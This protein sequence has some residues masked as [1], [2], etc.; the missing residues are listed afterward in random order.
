M[1]DAITWW[2][3][4][5][6]IGLAAFPLAFVLFCFLPDRGYSFSKVFGLLL[7]S[8]LVWIGASAHVIPNHRWSIVLVLAL[9]VALCTFLAFRCRRDF[10]AFLRN[11]WSHLLVMDLVFAAVYAAVLFFHSYNAD[12]TLWWTDNPAHNAFI[13][14]ILRSDYFPP[15]DPWLSG[16]SIHYY[17]FG[18]LMVATLTKLTDI[19]SRITFGL[20]IALT[21]ALTASGAFGL[22]YNLVVERAKQLKSVIAVA[23]LAALFV[24]VLSNIEGVFEL[25]AAHGIG[26]KGFYQLIDIHGLDGPR[27]SSA[28]YPTEGFWT[29]RAISFAR[30]TA[31]NWFPFY[32]LANG[33]LRPL[34]LSLPLLLL[35]LA[36]ALNLWRSDALLTIRPSWPTLGYLAFPA[37]VVGAMVVVHTWDAP[38]FIFITLLLVGLRNY[39]LQR[40]LSLSLI[41]RTLA[42]AA[43]LLL[44]AFLLYLPFYLCRTSFG[45]FSGIETTSG[46]SGARPHHLLYMWLPLFW[47][48]GSFAVVCLVKLRRPL[49]LA[50]M[51]AAPAF[52]VL[53]SWGAFLLLTRGAAELGDEFL[54]RGASWITVVLL[55]SLLTVTILALLNQ[56]A[57]DKEKKVHGEASVFALALNATAFL[58][59]LGIEFFW[60]DDRVFPPRFNT[61]LTVNYQAWVLFGISGAFTIYYVTAGWQRQRLG[62][63]LPKIAW[64]AATAMVVL[65]GFVY[66]LL[67]TFYTTDAFAKTRHLNGLF[68]MEFWNPDEYD[69]LLWLQTNVHG[70]PVVL[71]AAGDANTP[72]SYVSAYTGLPTVLGWRLQEFWWRGSWEPQAGRKEDIERVYT[73]TD[74]EEAKVILE[75]YDVEYVYVGPLE[76]QQYGEV[77]MAKFVYFM[78]IAYQNEGVIIYRMPEEGRSVQ[79]P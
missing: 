24:I 62:V 25:L 71:E 77:G 27:Q 65:A 75:R 18:H 16:N 15:E 11:R 52:L 4:V 51:A 20:A 39:L 9:I 35:V 21:T 76:R 79:A 40:S 59:L 60:I 2:L 74:P 7:L 32:S 1:I 61:V 70:T 64:A 73:T 57:L 55:M 26:S 69:A 23:L 34:T 38:A 37:L 49:A 46:E 53:G 17:Y 78:D 67:A 29:G 63:L 8:Y 31:F 33:D 41:G 56:L 10:V 43:V 54:A 36:T 72:L 14:S 30:N 50:P 44:L 19:P 3:A 22:L 48:A 12:I 42:F 5:E 13:N 45:A 47:L 58:V 68:A 66:P 6:L 28:W